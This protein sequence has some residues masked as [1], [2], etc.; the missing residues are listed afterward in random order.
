MTSAGASTW[1]IGVGELGRTL[2]GDPRQPFE[3]VGG[4]KDHAHLVPGVGD[5]VAEG[6]DGAR[7]VGR[8]ARRWRRRARRRCRARRR[9]C[10]GA[11]RRH[12]RPPRHCRRRRPRSPPARSMPQRRASS[13]GGRPKAGCPRRAAAS[14]S[15]SR[16]V[17]ARRSSDQSRLAT[18]SQKRA[19]GVGHVGDVVAGQAAGGRSPWAAAPRRCAGEDLRLV[20]AHPGDLRRGEARHGDVAGDLAER[21]GRRLRSRRTR[22]WRGRRSRGSPGAAPRRLASRQIAPCMWP[23]SPMPRRPARPCSR[24]SVPMVPSTAC[25]QSSG[26]C[27]DQPGFGRETRRLWLAWPISRWS[28]SKSTVLT[29]EVPMSMPR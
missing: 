6:V 5:G 1:P 17:T 27:S 21:A 25:H 22:P 26:S 29:D 2:A 20:L 8:E 10:P 15:R 4:R 3:A 7:G 9:R 23:E 11:P 18:S 19:G 12:R 14:G 13:G 24:A 16:P 28:R